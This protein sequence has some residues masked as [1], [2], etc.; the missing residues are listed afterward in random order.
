MIHMPNDPNIEQWTRY[1]SIPWVISSAYEGEGKWEIE[2]LLDTFYTVR[3]HFAELRPHLGPGQRV[4]DI[5]IDGKKVLDSIPPR[6]S[7]S[8]LRG[9]SHGVV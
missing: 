7:A 9:R 2:D 4:F 5:W 6:R 1:D 3:L 8:G